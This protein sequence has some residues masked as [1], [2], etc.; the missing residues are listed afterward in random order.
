MVYFRK[1][2]H[3]RHGSTA[4]NSDADGGG[5]GSVGGGSVGGGEGGGGRGEQVGMTILH[6]NTGT[7]SRTHSNAQSSSAWTDA[8]NASTRYSTASIQH[9]PDPS[10]IE[11]IETR[12]ESTSSPPPPSSLHSTT[13]KWTSATS[14][15][16]DAATATA[17]RHRHRA[18]T[19][20]SST[21][22]EDK[23]YAAVA[24]RVTSVAR[25]YSALPQYVEGSAGT[26]ENPFRAEPGSALDPKGS[27]FSARAWAQAVLRMQAAEPERQPGRTVG[28]AF[29]NLSVRGASAEGGCEYQPTVGNVVV[30]GW[31][32][33]WRRG[34]G[35]KGGEKEILRGFD[36]VVEAGETLLVLGP[37]GS[38][39]STLLRTVAGET[40]GVRVDEGSY[41][42]YQGEFFF[43]GW[44]MGDCG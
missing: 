38:G 26:T 16:S 27:S 40:E 9:L 20:D 31:E 5:G 29:A 13:T 15:K 32:W 12:D 8:E 18:T 21:A 28:V 41:L 10:L 30:R 4:A 36:G 23:D 33:V 37:P 22:D 3:S 6:R 19:I 2:I 35:G 34:R 44:W 24:R 43:E 1:L 39:C 7:H 17:R 25:R 42:N 14:A 11:L